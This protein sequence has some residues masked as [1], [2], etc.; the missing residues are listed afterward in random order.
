MKRMLWLALIPLAL[1]AA[2]IAAGCGG[3]TEF[4][5]EAEGG[6]HTVAPRSASAERGGDGGN[7]EPDGPIDGGAVDNSDPNAPKT[8]ESKQLISFDCRF[9]TVDAAEPGAL[10]NHIYALQARLENGAVKGTYRILDTGEER[11]FRESHRFLEELRGLVSLYD[12]AQYNGRSYSV[13]GLPEDYG[14]S[15]EVRYASG[16]HIYAA[17]NQDNFLPWGAM[18]ELIK[19]FE[20]GAAV[21]PMAQDFS[22]TDAAAELPGTHEALF[23]TRADSAAVSFYARDEGVFL[24]RSRDGQTG[25]ELG[26]SDVFRD[27]DSLPGLLL[28]EF[29]KAYPDQSFYDDA[30]DFIRQSVEGE[31]GNISFALG[32]GF[33][34]IFAGAYILNDAPDGYHITLSYQLYPDLVR[35]FYTASPSRWL[36]PLDYDTV[37]WRGDLSVGFRMR[38][39]A[40]PESEEVLW[41]VTSEGGG[42]E[43][44]E[45]T[46][47]GYPP[48]CWLAHID[49]RDFIYL[50]VPAGDISISTRIYEVTEQAVTKRTYDTLDLAIRADTPLN[51]NEV[52]MNLN[53]PVFTPVMMLLPYGTYRI[54]TNG[55]PELAE[56]AY[57]LDGTW[58][59]LRESGRYNPADPADAAVSG[60]M[61][62]LVAGERLRPYRTDLR[63]WIDFITEDGR[64]VRFTIDRFAGDMQLDNF[65]TLDSVFV[66]EGAG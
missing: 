35:P 33:V 48:E 17:D 13:A 32:Y 2:V 16:E 58:A 47:Y 25:K 65:G 38:S 36:I 30:Q 44:H 7:E 53:E 34:H 37:Y 57:A 42:A 23:V 63:S 61:W 50:R 4:V 11:P 60:G 9:S 27:L 3:S 45:E 26:F 6:P 8:I 49:E 52:R 64:V 10:G 41:V 59:R 28:M 39:F 62:N 54:E 5:K 66:P 31:D 55:L 51:P 29:E 15:L 12:L 21:L 19:L 56:E 18:N 24:T 43:P 14:A 1:A 22:A 40:F 20:R 46:F